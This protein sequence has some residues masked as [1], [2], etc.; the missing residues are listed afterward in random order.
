MIGANPRRLV[1]VRKQQANR[2]GLLCHLYRFYRFFH[3][4]VHSSESG[5]LVMGF[6]V[7]F[8]FIEWEIIDRVALFI[9]AVNIL[10]AK[11]LGQAE[12]DLRAF[13]WIGG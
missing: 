12:G 7:C 3:V 5:P 13:I 2:C 8:N 4:S 11:P 6:R 9:D 1:Y 10:V